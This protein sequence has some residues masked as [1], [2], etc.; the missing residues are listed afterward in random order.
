MGFWI[1]ALASVIDSLIVGTLIILASWLLAGQSQA[2][3][4]LEGLVPLLYLAAAIAMKS[5]TPGKRLLGLRVVD[6]QGHSLGFWRSLVREVPGKFLS[7]L[8]L[9]L[10]FLWAA[11]DR[12]KRGWHDYL[13]RSYVVRKPG[14]EVAN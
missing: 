13:G 9:G 2:V 10:G 3:E 11:W 12:R 5:E 6:A 8:F 7:G 1:R 4:W 14:Q